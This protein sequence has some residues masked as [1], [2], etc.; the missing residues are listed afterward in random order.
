MIHADNLPFVADSVDKRVLPKLHLVPHR[1]PLLAQQ[2]F[3]QV[4]AAR[5]GTAGAE[6]VMNGAAA[7]PEAGAQRRL[8]GPRARRTLSGQILRELEYSLRISLG[9][10]FDI[11]RALG[12]RAYHIFVNLAVRDSASE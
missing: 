5:F 4:R 9:R 6:G 1:G 12:G 7:I 8:T 3:E 10:K 11:P 2:R